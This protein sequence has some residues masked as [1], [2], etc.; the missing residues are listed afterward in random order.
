MTSATPTVRSLASF[1]LLAVAAFMTVIDLTIVNTAP[2]TIRRSCRIS[3]TSLLWIVDPQYPD[4]AHVAALLLAAGPPIYSAPPHHH[5][6]G[7]AVFTA[8]IAGASL[9][10]G[11]CPDLD[12]AVQGLGAALFSYS[13][14]S[15][16]E[17]CSPSAPERNKALGVSGDSAALGATFRVVFG[18][19]LDALRDAA[20]E[21]C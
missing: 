5:C 1:S 7:L 6:F 13:P 14:S 19:L 21:F 18:D 3:P 17:T 16:V 2:S 15:T 8:R 9:A 20:D 12:A 11:D 4:S 10:G